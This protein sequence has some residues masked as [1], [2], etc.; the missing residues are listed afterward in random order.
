V[1]RVVD[2]EEIAVEVKGNVDVEDEDGV[3]VP[4]CDDEN[5]EL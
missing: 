5:D 2:V 1:G 4:L 3:E